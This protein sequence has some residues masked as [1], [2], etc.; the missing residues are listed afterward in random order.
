MELKKEAMTV[1]MT[2]EADENREY[3][4]RGAVHVSD[5]KYTSADNG[6]V[7]DTTGAYVANFSA[8]QD[9]SL[10]IRYQDGTLTGPLR[11]SVLNL[12]QDFIASAKA[13]VNEATE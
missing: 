10:S 7:F 13:E 5:G 8:G 2:N 4:I 11:V 1:T 9:E 6:S 3:T 12:I